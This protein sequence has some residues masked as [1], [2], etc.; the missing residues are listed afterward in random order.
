MMRWLTAILLLFANCI[1]AQHKQAT[2]SGKIVDE[3]DKP[4]SGVSVTILGKQR[5]VISSDSGTF[6]IHVPAHQTIS[7]I[8]THTNYL[9]QQRN[10]YL[11]TNEQEY[12][13]ISL[14][15][16]KGQL[17]EV[18]IKN[19]PSRKEPGMITINPKLSH[20][21]P[22][23]TGG[24]EALIKTL[25][26][27][28]NELTSQYNVRGGNYDENLVYINDFE[29]YR[30]YLI[31][32]GQQE[33]LSLINPELARKVNFYT[34]GFQSRYGDKMSSVL[35]IEY[36]KPVAFGGS[37]YTSLL[38]QGIHIEGVGFKN[39][40]SFL[41][42]ARN[43]SNR[44]LLSSQPTVGAYLPAAS[45]IQ[46]QITYT[47][48][49]NWQIDL[50]G[51]Y[52][53]SRFTFNPESVKKTTS[54]F[55]PYFTANL[56][57]DIY[58]EGQERDR[59]NTLLGGITIHQRI[60]KNLGFKWIASRFS[61][62]EQEYFDIGAA[63]LFGNRDF[64][65]QSSTFG[66]I[67][68]PMGAGYYQDY[69]RNKLDIDV[70]SVAHK[71]FFEAGNHSVQW[72]VNWEQSTISDQL[73]QWQYRDSAGYS[74]PVQT[75]DNFN[76]YY[77]AHSAIRLNINKYSGYLQDSWRLR[78]KKSDFNITGGVRANYNDLNEEWLISPRIQM[79]YK[80]NKK[81]NII[82]KAAAGL[83][84][85]PPFYREL[86]DYNGNVHTNIRAQK[87][88]QAVIGFDY[89]FT[90]ANDKPMR[91]TTEA[92]YKNMWNVIPYDIDNVKIRY[93][94]NFTAKAYAT[95]V[96]FR[97]YGELLKDA[98]SWI[99]LGFMR[100]RENLDNDFYYNYYNAAGELITSN[101]SDKIA[102]DS[103]KINVGYV[104]RPSDRL[105]TAGLFLQDYLTTNKNFR[106]YLNIIYGS[107]MPFNI[108]NSTKYRNGLTINPYIRADIGM[109]VLL[110]KERTK[111]RSHDPFRALESA[112]FS[113][114][115]FNIINRENT[116][117]YQLIRDFSNYTYAI[118]NRLTPRLVNF[119]LLT[120]F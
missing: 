100:T 77:N 80:P 25:V 111:R 9:S 39:K 16:G 51:I 62:R 108:P 82:Y 92:Y 29:V 19:D 102:A 1:Y 22:S 120:R 114:E 109:S 21:I 68:N 23:T 36:K 94:N 43:K 33:G 87:S 3:E 107:N 117:S 96:E 88:M 35:D 46:G 5:G 64:D 106:I 50:L 116:I 30:P 89:A 85:Q 47:L 86:R 69:A 118:P 97:L 65:R 37:A 110:L 63:Y 66:E 72:G 103:T 10:Y 57:L 70:W 74:L 11:N 59:Y 79:L 71:G 12:T 42:G 91:F 53:V 93:L 105:I 17:A 83:Y 90:G 14:N 34:G 31:S 81:Q 24:V 67:I 45:D 75:D 28:N 76:L 6:T 113:L 7:L 13:H 48:N 4:I 78:N 38:E 26:G 18:V 101:S 56:G 98:E 60:N 54:V 8:F 15:H 40:L 52:A 61:D 73:K 49:N 95:G 119:K 20:A 32:S 2:I 104:R 99:S 41:I 112:W 44:N 115:I 27:S 84:Q 55:S 58:F